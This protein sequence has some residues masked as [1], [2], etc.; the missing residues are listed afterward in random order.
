MYS[1]YYIQKSEVKCCNLGIWLSSS[2]LLLENLQ[3]TN[4]M[5]CHLG[6][7]SAVY[8]D[9]GLMWMWPYSENMICYHKQSTRA[10]HKQPEIWIRKHISTH[11]ASSC[12]EA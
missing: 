8:A 5:R 6:P 10:M 9:V 11:N 4:K 3:A 2:K 7:D 12:I 1:N